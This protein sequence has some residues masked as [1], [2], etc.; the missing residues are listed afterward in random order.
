MHSKPIHG[1]AIL[2]QRFRIPQF[3]CAPKPPTYTLSLRIPIISRVERPLLALPDNM[4]QQR[5]YHA[6]AISMEF[7]NDSSDDEA[8]LYEDD[9]DNEE[10]EATDRGSRSTNPHPIT[11]FQEAFDESI[12]DSAEQYRTGKPALELSSLSAEERRKRL[13][14]GEDYNDTYSA[15]WREDPASRV[16]PLKKIVAQITYGVHLLHVQMA[17]SNEEVVKILQRHI[18]QVDELIRRAD[19]DLGMALADIEMRISHLKFAL[20]DRTTF[21]VML[22]NRSYRGEI[23]R[24]NDLIKDMIKRTESLMDDLLGD[25]K[26]GHDSI[27]EM[28]AYMGRIGS[29][30][31][32]STTDL[33]IYNTMLR[34]TE[35]WLECFDSLKL[36]GKSLSGCLMQLSALVEEMARRAENA[37]R[38]QVRA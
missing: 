34:N 23:L 20:A 29:T 10:D 16:H 15:M 2:D 22:E 1:C 18:D 6:R 25:I 27:K 33:G 19:E 32:M 36:E 28:S 37:S 24:G 31:P 13:L 3:G 4:S 30:W 8:I 11:S 5:Q 21:D 7:Y 12:A 14:V 9:S 38:K 35:G 26:I 17:V